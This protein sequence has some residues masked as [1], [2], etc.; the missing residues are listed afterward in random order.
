MGNETARAELGRED[1]VKL[2]ISAILDFVLPA[3]RG[4]TYKNRWCNPYKALKLVQG[5]DP[6]F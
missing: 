2:L 1:L 3:S 6:V 4:I 5:E